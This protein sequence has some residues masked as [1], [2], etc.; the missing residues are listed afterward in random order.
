MRW[1]LS[2]GAPEIAHFGPV[3]DPLTKDLETPFFELK[4]IK[5]LSQLLI[6]RVIYQ[7][8]ADTN[9]VRLQKLSN[10]SWN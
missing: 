9:H 8:V 4:P 5:P 2:F 7:K 3:D 10:K 1:P 6:F